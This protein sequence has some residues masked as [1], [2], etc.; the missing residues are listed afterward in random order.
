MSYP[1][2]TPPGSHPPPTSTTY[3]YGAYHHPPGAYGHPQTPGAY[4][5]QAPA[6]Q[7]GVTGYGWT[8]PYSY[9]PQHPQSAVAHRPMVQ[10]P[11][12][13]TAHTSST[14]NPPPVP[15]RTTTFTSYTP[16]YMR[17]SVTAA[18]TGGATGRGGRKQS[19]LKGLFSK[20]RKLRTPPRSSTR[21]CVQLTPLVCSE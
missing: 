11:A 7:P 2:Y 18:A 4:S 21:P 5:Y 13:V 16:S 1:H 3:P 9:V 14:P 19:N 12:P 15:Q 10:T 17:E 6:Y 8:Y 20:E